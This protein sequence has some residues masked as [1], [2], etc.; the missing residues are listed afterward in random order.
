MTP[1]A[2]DRVGSTVAANRSERR[3]RRP[4]ARSGCM[5]TVWGLVP[6]DALRLSLR[7][8]D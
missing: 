2:A 5:P 7:R 6:R 3:L 8:E 1:M 4:L